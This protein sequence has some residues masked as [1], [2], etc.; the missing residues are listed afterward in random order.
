ME[1]I[2]IEDRLPQHLERVLVFGYVKNYK[3][4]HE[5]FTGLMNQA[6]SINEWFCMGKQIIASHWM[7]LPE[8][9]KK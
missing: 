7:P 4:E 1:W 9:P 8:A 3:E 6:G 5:I 2:S